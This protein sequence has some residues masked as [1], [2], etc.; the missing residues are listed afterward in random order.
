[1]PEFN[2]S[3]Y[4]RPGLQIEEIEEIRES[5]LAFDHD[6]NDRVSIETLVSSIK[7]L[8]FDRK[9]PQIFKVIKEIKGD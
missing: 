1:M 5:F 8:G 2:P 6:E 9:S 4:S 3:L 7:A